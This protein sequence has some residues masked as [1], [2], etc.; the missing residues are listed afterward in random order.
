MTRDEKEI[1]EELT[2]SVVR[3]EYALLGDEEAKVDGIAQK[4]NKNSKY[5]EK[6][7]KFKYAVW[8]V[9]AAGGAGIREFFSYMFG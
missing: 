9:V 3:I 1:L 6:D 5:I 8:G 2:K 4:V 7:K